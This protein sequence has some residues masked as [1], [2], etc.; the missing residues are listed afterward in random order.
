MAL[1]SDGLGLSP[2]FFLR[3]AM[4]LAAYLVSTPN[5][6]MDFW[7]FPQMSE[8]TNCPVELAAKDK[9]CVTD[10]LYVVQ[11]ESLES[12]EVESGNDQSC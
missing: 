12:T 8:S 3:T 7:R 9:S 11:I 5:F 1:M 2:Y 4:T 6:S 10:I